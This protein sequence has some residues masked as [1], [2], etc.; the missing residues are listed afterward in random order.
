MTK[1]ILLFLTLRKPNFVAG[2][3]NKRPRQWHPFSRP[4]WSRMI[5]KKVETRVISRLIPMVQCSYLVRDQCSTHF[6]FDISRTMLHLPP[7]RR[8]RCQIRQYVPRSCISRP[9]RKPHS[10]R[11]PIPPLPIALQTV[12]EDQGESAQKDTCPALSVPSQRQLSYIK[13]PSPV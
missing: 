3:W 8:C 2:P 9:L 10:V 7:A 6:T 11:R 13:A 12:V 5:G 4:M 1:A